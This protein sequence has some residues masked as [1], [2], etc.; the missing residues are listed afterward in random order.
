MQVCVKREGRVRAPIGGARAVTLDGGGGNN[1]GDRRRE[2]PNL[3]QEDSFARPNIFTEE[4]DDVF[5]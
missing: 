1:P 2:D 5:S 3:P 4:L